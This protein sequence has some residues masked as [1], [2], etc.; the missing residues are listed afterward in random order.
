MA[1]TTAAAAVASGAAYTGPV[2]PDLYLCDDFYGNPV[3]S[4]CTQALANMPR[5][6]AAVSY[7]QP[8]PS[9]SD[10]DTMYPGASM[11][12]AIYNEGLQQQRLFILWNLDRFSPLNCRA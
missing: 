8:M 5:G 7:Y 6:A 11:F 3:V 10:N 12:P 2:A 1:A 4:A 9:Q